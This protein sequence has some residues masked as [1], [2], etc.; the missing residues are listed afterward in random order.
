MPNYGPGG[1]PCKK[2]G[3]ASRTFLRVKKPFWF[4]LG[5]FSLKRST[6]EAFE[7]CF[8][9]LSP[10]MC[11]EIMCCF[12]IDHFTVVRSVTRPLNGSEARA[13]PA[14]TQTSLLLSCKC[15]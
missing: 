4:P 14:S 13:D 15:T 5:V 2:D 11:Q 3:R 8:R 1:L 7:V 10:K 9:V 12:R 6:A